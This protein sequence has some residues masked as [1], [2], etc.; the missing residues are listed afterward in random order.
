[1]KMGTVPHEAGPSSGLGSNNWNRRCL[2]CLDLSL[3]EL[4]LDLSGLNWSSLRNS[5]LG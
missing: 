5:C 3:R 4:R 2:S 1:M